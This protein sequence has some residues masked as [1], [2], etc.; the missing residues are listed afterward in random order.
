MTITY[1]TNTLAFDYDGGGVDFN[2]DVSYDKVELGI[3]YFT[4]AREDIS[5]ITVQPD[6]KTI[7][8]EYTNLS[9]TSYEYGEIDIQ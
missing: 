9:M 2:V 6:S 1:T 3:V 7:V 5:R 8:V 4:P